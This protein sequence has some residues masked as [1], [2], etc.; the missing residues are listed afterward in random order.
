MASIMT[1]DFDILTGSEY[2]AAL[3][4]QF[5]AAGKG[6]RILLQTMSFDPSESEIAAVM[7]ALHGAARRGADV[8]FMIDAISFMFHNGKVGPL[9][10]G[11]KLPAQ[12]PQIFEAKRQWL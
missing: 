4:E 5:K 6:S 3:V 9:W 11:T 8:T 10:R 2:F 12:M 7:E 1:S